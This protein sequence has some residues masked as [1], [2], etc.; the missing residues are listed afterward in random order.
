MHEENFLVTVVTVSYREL[1]YRGV[2]LP[3]MSAVTDGGE[4][5]QIPNFKLQRS[6]NIQ[7]A[8][9]K[10]RNGASF[11]KRNLLL[12]PFFRFGLVSCMAHFFAW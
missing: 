4:K 10:S 2:G 1:P 12:G 9:R 5:V 8:K 11:R 6:S 3:E 7:Y